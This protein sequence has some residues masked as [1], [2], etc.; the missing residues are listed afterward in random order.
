[1]S[2]EQTLAYWCDMMVK[3]YNTS[4][5]DNFPTSLKRSLQEEARQCVESKPNPNYHRTFLGIKRKKNRNVLMRLI[6]N[7]F[8]SKQVKTIPNVD[9]IGGPHTLTLHWSAKYN[10]II[11]IFGEYHRNVVCDYDNMMLI[12]DY[13]KNLFRRSSAFIDFFLEIP[14]FVKGKYKYNFDSDNRLNILRNQNKECIETSQRQKNRY[15]DTK[16]IHFIDIRQGPLSNEE[17]GFFKL[18]NTLYFEIYFNLFFQNLINTIT[19]KKIEKKEYILSILNYMFKGDDN[20]FTDTIDFILFGTEETYEEFWKKQMETHEFISDEVSKS[21]EETKIREFA[22]E[23][24]KTDKYRLRLILLINKLRIYLTKCYVKKG[25]Y[26]FYQLS[27]D[28]YIIFLNNLSGFNSILTQCNSILVDIYTLSRMFKKFQLNSTRNTDEPEEP[29][30]II[31]YAGDEHSKRVRRFL[32]KLEFDLISESKGDFEVD[33]CV[34]IRHFEQPF[35]SSWPPKKMPQTQM[36][37]KMSTSDFQ[38]Q[39]TS[40]NEIDEE[41]EL[42]VLK[43]E[44]ILIY[45]G[46]DSD[47]INESGVQIDM[48]LSK[49]DITFYP[50]EIGSYDYKA[51]VGISNSVISENLIRRFPFLENLKHVDYV[52]LF[53]SVQK[54]LESKFITP[55]SNIVI[56]IST[57]SIIKNQPECIRK[58]VEFYEKIGF[59]KMFPTHYE[60]VMERIDNDL[61]DY[62]PM[63]GNVEN[64]TEGWARANFENLSVLL[65]LL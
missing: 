59:Q 54:A 64:I 14:M 17:F 52:V 63:I 7:Y 43:H 4:I 8:R 61:H 55:E 16:R 21:T 62:I 45:K 18:N 57:S 49:I 26:N 24:F 42:D 48:V 37:K 36:S 22:E 58:L 40:I 35:F 11:Y 34:D 2:E 13:L 27:D 1:M 23:E 50:D 19:I 15:C 51:L 56:S 32:E 60:D 39:T 3:T 29:H 25:I 47:F 12:E 41:T 6:N 28:E 30:N 9:F 53:F 20:K 10:K 38:I 31:M 46:N 5:L 65:E 44:A 33:F